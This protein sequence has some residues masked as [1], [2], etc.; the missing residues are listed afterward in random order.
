MHGG[1]GHPRR[2]ASSGWMVVRPSR[3]GAGCEKGR[4]RRS[5]GGW[6]CGR[7]VRSGAGDGCMHHGD[8]DHR[9]YASTR[10]CSCGGDVKERDAA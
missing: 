5:F 2:G 4:R 6:S 3:L 9:L 7:G 8:L 1:D 10:R